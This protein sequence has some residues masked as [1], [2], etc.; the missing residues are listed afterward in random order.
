MFYCPLVSY[1]W[2]LRRSQKNKQFRKL[3]YLR[4]PIFFYC[5]CGV[6]ENSRRG[7][8]NHIFAYRMES[9]A[10]NFVVASLRLG[11]HKQDF[12]SNPLYVYF[13]SAFLSLRMFCWDFCTRKKR[14]KSIFF[15]LA[16]FLRNKTAER[17][18]SILFFH[19]SWKV[20]LREIGVASKKLSMKLL[21]WQNCQTITWN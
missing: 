2:L 21:S 15:S 20:W 8:V 18:V 9:N 6:G 16:H 11:D 10:N 4:S 12:L 14:W 13:I 19:V 17:C 1:N 5:S 7:I 3:L